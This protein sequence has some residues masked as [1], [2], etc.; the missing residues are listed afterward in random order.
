MQNRAVPEVFKFIV[1]FA[2][3]DDGGLKV[4]SP[5]VPGFR[6]SHADSQAVCA[7]II[8]ALET[9]LSERMGGAVKVSIVRD[10]AERDAGFTLPE[11]R[12]SREYGAQIVH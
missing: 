11:L 7:D 10:L 8:P 4:W 12:P 6:L 3:R 5:D 2:Q 1:R 9:I